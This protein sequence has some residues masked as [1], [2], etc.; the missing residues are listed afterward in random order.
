ML[1]NLLEDC[2]D[3]WME[4]ILDNKDCVAVIN[5]M[6]GQLND[7]DF[8]DLFHSVV[9]L[10][11]SQ[12]VFHHFDEETSIQ[13]VKSMLEDTNDNIPSLKSSY[14]FVVKLKGLSKYVERE[15][16]I[17]CSFNL[18][19]L[20]YAVLAS[21]NC[22]GEHLFSVKYDEK[23]YYC[24]QYDGGYDTEYASDYSLQSLELKEKDKL[25]IRYDLSENYMF[26]VV[27]KDTV[28]YD[29]IVNPE[30][31]KVIK[32]KG[33]GIWEDNHDLLEL[34]YKDRKAFDEM[35]EIEDV[36]DGWIPIEE[37]YDFNIDDVK[38]DFYS[39]YIV[40]RTIYE[41]FFEYP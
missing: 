16:E 6:K 8:H 11:I 7:E 4:E 41:D 39:D 25:T 13:V 28:E 15:I 40:L 34:Y 5:D 38:N 33:M 24:D 31:M 27:L 2:I 17:P 3:K 20:C 30:D 1:V 21:M 14:I 10:G 32:G 26:S 18:L 35:I 22:D 19:E 37:K 9:S 23:T 29:C 36:G 12:A